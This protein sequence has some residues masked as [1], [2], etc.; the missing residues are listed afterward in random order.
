MITPNTKVTALDILRE[1]GVENPEAK[2]GKVRVRIGGLAGINSPDYLIKLSPEVK[3]VEVIVGEKIYDLELSKGN[4]E[5]NKDV[6]EV[7]DDA[8]RVL[9]E[10]GK[11]QS[12]AAEHRS[13][14]K[15]LA[16]RVIASED[17]EVEFKPTGAEKDL[18]PEALDMVDAIREGRE[19][20]QI[21][22]KDRPVEK[23]KSQ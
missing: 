16:R 18:M 6:F 9:E 15:D 4:K 1:C 13:A 21:K 11:A 5:S 23:V 7:T 12:E 19:A 2:F 3:N 10:K 22:D 14:V 20:A 17:A 8:K